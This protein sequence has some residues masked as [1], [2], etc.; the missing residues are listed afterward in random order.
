MVG[1]TGKGTLTAIRLRTKSLNIVRPYAGAVC[2][3]ILF[4]HDN[5]RPPVV[6]ACRYLLEDERTDTTDLTPPHTR[7]T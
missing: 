5:A 2:P 6:R 7:L 4:V 1:H 3:R